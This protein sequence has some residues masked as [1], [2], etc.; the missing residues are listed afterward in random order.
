MHLT[1]VIGRKNNHALNGAAANSEKDQR[2]SNFYKI[3]S[4]FPRESRERTPF[5]DKFVTS[6]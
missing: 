5:D 2:G 6:G 1:I 4:S 3:L